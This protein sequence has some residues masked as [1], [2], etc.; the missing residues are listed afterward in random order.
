MT[1]NPS[2]S[3]SRKITPASASPSPLQVG[4][5]A[6]K[7][8]GK[9]ILV[10]MAVI[11]SLVVAGIVGLFIMATSSSSEPAVPLPLSQKVI[12]SGSS[13]I[14]A[15]VNISGEIGEDTP[16]NPLGGGVAGVSA[17]RMTR[18]L[19]KLADDEAV[20]AVVL[21][22]DTPGGGVVASDEIYR[23]VKELRDQKPVVVS[24]GNVAASGGYYIAA[25]A[26]H[27]IANPAT[28]TGSIGVIAQFP[29]LSGLFEKIGLEFRTFK[30]GEFKDMGSP[31]RQITPEETA[32]LNTITT[33]AYDQF[34]MAIVDG[35]Q[36]D[37]AKVRQLG[38]GRIYTGQ[39]AKD[40]GL[41]DQLGTLDDAVAVAGKM[42]EVSD[43]TVSEYSDQSF[44][45]A[46][47]E[48]KLEGLGLGAQ[49]EQLVPTSHSGLYYL[50]DI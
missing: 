45:Q 37:Q 8:V 44:F 22:I 41:V 42:A 16:S 19:D 20:K 21:R 31:S 6:F 40:N 36:M 30:S 50:M 17:R 1:E 28:L 7:W 3:Q 27:I 4:V 35:R 9:A 24:M 48:S 2:S 33:Q 32:I 25:G 5:D 13:D 26:S 43:P 34:V 18:L 15:I 12:E 11:G 46:L 29:E 49:L 38:D 47:F 39:Q 23:K 10:V 14:V